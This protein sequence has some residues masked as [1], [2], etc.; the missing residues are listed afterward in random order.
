MK[1]RETPV[2]V[3]WAKTNIQ[4]GICG[5]IMLKH[6]QETR[7]DLGELSSCKLS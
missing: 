7:Q 6:I 4:D 5:H 2:L 3:K 1:Y